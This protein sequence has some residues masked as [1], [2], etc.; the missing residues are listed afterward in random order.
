MLLVTSVPFRTVP[1]QFNHGAKAQPLGMGSGVRT[2]QHF[3]WPPH[4][5]CEHNL[6]PIS[7]LDKA[8]ACSSEILSS[9]SQLFQD[10]R[11]KLI[12]ATPEKLIWSSKFQKNSGEGLTE[13][14]PQTSF[15]IFL[16]LW[17]R[18]GLCPIQTLHFWRV[19]VPLPCL[20]TRFANVYVQLPLNERAKIMCLSSKF[21]KMNHPRQKQIFMFKTF[22]GA[23]VDTTAPY[24]HA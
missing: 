4:N 15:P 6:T 22:L 7:I 12:K 13:P 23:T 1:V 17:P 10:F 9:K 11:F 8:H 16:G 18:F 5:Y 24:L 3:N 20:G 19:V 14:P 2:P 21:C